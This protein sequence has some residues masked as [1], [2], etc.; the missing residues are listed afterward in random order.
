MEMT[1]LLLYLYKI[2]ENS[3]LILYQKNWTWHNFRNCCEF[4]RNKPV[5]STLR[6]L[7]AI[8]GTFWKKWNFRPETIFSWK[9]AQEPKPTSG[10]KSGRFSKKSLVQYKTSMLVPFA[11]LCS[12]SS[13]KAEKSCTLDDNTSLPR[14][15]FGLQRPFWRVQPVDEAPSEPLNQWKK[16]SAGHVP[17]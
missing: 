13:W 3:N 4:R 15:R 5:L 11:P 6:R 8:S 9:W 14:A 10:Q 2:F 1:S 16:R 12:I 17:S 7:R